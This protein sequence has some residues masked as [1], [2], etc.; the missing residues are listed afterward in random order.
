MLGCALLLPACSKTTSEEANASAYL[1]FESWVTAHYP[2]AARTELGSCILSETPGSGTALGDGNDIPCVLVDYTIRDLDRNV[3]RTT[4][5]SLARQVGGYDRRYH[6]APQVWHRGQNFLFAGLDD[7]LSRMKVGGSVT[8]DIPGWLFTYARY[9]GAKAYRENATGSDAIY[10]IHVHEA[11]PDIE[12]WEQDTL[13]R[14]FKRVQPDVDPDGAMTET[15]WYYVQKGAPTSETA[16][17]SN[18]KIDLNYTAR[19][20]DGQVFDT[21]EADTAYVHGIYDPS[22]KYEPVFFHWNSD[23][24][25]V[26]MGSDESSVIEGFAKAISSMHR[27][28]KGRCFFW[29]TL[30]YNVSGTG[31]TTGIG[32]LVPPYS[33]LQFDIEITTT[34]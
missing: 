23:P 15:G 13:R 21:T 5:E 24:E 29:S 27:G 14:Y 18:Q 26:T 6:Y 28:E 22:K 32:Y 9:D 7:V 2:N 3:E 1:Y 19:R 25:E 11:I 34:E 8:V 10:E 20:P 4:D 16:F 12:Q 17:S 30:G 33:P 31:Y